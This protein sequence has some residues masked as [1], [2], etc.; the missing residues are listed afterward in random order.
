[1]RFQRLNLPMLSSSLYWQNQL[2]KLKR[3]LRYEGCP[4][5]D[6]RPKL[7]FVNGGSQLNRFAAGAVI[8]RA[9]VNHDAGAARS[10]TPHQF[11][12]DASDTDGIASAIQS[13]GN[14]NEPHT[15]TIAC[16]PTT[17]SRLKTAISGLEF[18]GNI[19]TIATISVSTA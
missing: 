16:R 3:H 7:P 18:S 12:P 15:I 13:L 6:I 14:S 5:D 4:F 19:Y 8:T 11:M 2:G 9:D 1:M 17:I 10:K